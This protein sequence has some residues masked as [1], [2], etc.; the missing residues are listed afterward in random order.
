MTHRSRA[1][2]W[3]I[4]RWRKS[5]AYTDLTNE[6]QGA[7]R[8]LLDEGALRG[9]AIPNDERV[10]AKASGDAVRWPAI[11]DVVMARFTLEADGC[12]HHHTLDDVLRKSAYAAERQR[13]HRLNG[14]G[15]NGRE[16]E[17]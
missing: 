17:A 6:Q 12:W 1:L 15:Q 4:D 11:R 7:Y 14:H 2:L 16:S 5:T 10:L 9:G 8:N 3:W 13:R